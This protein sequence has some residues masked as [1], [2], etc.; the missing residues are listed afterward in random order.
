[1]NSGLAEAREHLRRIKIDTWIGMGFSSL[2]AFFVILCTA[3]TLHAAGITEIETSAQ[4]AEVLR[5]LAGEL[6]FFLFAPGIIGAGLRWTRRAGLAGQAWQRLISPAA[7]D[8]GQ[9][10]RAIAP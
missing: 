7:V 1:M 4:A 8:G 6:T 5:P 9:A 3:V 2:I 10:R